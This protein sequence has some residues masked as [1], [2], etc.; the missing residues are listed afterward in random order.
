MILPFGGLLGLGLWLFLRHKNQKR[1]FNVVA[2]GKTGV[3]KSTLINAF[4]G[5]EVAKTGTGRPVTAHLAR[6]T[7]ENSPIAVYDS[8]GIET[9][10]Q[11][12]KY[13]KEI[14]DLIPRKYIH[15]CWYCINAEGLRIEPNE[16]A[17][18]KKIRDRIPLVVVLTQFA[19]SPDQKEFLEKVCG[20][21]AGAWIKVFPVMAKEKR[22]ESE[23]GTINVPAHGIADLKERTG[24]LYNYHFKQQR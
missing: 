17:I 20:E 8:R 23:Y 14:Y 12:I 1:F 15:L 4:F 7:I 2:I 9:G 10:E 13:M 16:I 18:I 19:G 6:H 5:R 21:F 24:S 3:G 22:S 11:S